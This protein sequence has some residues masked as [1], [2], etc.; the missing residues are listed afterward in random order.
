MDYDKLPIASAITR[1]VKLLKDKKCSFK[2][3][4]LKEGKFHCFSG[5]PTERKA[6]IKSINDVCGGDKGSDAD[7]DESENDVDESEDEDDVINWITKQIN[8]LFC[9]K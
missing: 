5:K 9:N 3:T 1:L 6:A 4:F 8:K 2:D 7:D